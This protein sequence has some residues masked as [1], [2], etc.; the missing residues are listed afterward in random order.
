M[1]TS[2][3]TTLK[4][5]NAT[6]TQDATPAM[7]PATPPDASGLSIGV[8]SGG[9]ACRLPAT[10]TMIAPA[11]AAATTGRQRRERS[12]PSGISSSGRVM[13]QVIAGAHRDC[14]AT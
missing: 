4:M 6:P 8:S 7:L 2:A 13:P 5:N 3:A 14:T 1:Q 10:T 9:P 12:R 11:T